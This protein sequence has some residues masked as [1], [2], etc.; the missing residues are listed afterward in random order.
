MFKYCALVCL[1]FTITNAYLTLNNT[2]SS[3]FRVPVFNA[4]K[5]NVEYEKHMNVSADEYIFLPL[6]E[7]FDGYNPCDER[8]FNQEVFERRLIT[9]FS[10]NSGGN[11]TGS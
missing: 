3:K 6:H 10:S 11:D 1:F 4:V 7:P 9:N 2:S 5:W 8:T